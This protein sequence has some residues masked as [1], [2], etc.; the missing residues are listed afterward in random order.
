M[1]TAE[2]KADAWLGKPFHLDALF[3]CVEQ[4]AVLP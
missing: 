1:R 2:I 4:H 3:A